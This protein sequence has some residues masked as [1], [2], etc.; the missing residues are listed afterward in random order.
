MRRYV[1]VLI[2]MSFFGSSFFLLEVGGFSLTLF[3]VALLLVALIDLCYKKINSKSVIF[4]SSTIIFILITTIIILLSLFINTP[5]LHWLSGLINL[6]LLLLFMNIIITNINEEDDLKNYIGAFLMG[7]FISMIVALFELN[8]GIKFTESYLNDYPVGSFEYTSLSKFPVAFLY[9]PNNLA[10]VLL[11]S[12]PVW[13]F[14]YFRFF[15]SKFNYLLNF[16]YKFIVIYCI[17][18]TGS[19]SSLLLSLAYLMYEYIS[20]KKYRVFYLMIVLVLSLFIYEIFKLNLPDFINDFAVRFDFDFE[21][22]LLFFINSYD[23]ARIDLIEKAINLSSKNY[24]IGGGPFYAESITGFPTHAFLIDIIADFGILGFGVFS[25]LILK[26]IRVI[27][28]TPS[29]Y[30]TNKYILSII[31]LFFIGSFVPPTIYTLFVYFIPLSFAYG[32]STIYS[33]KGRDNSEKNQFTIL[34]K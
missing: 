29:L 6:L 25:Y 19:R 24:F 5:S 3:R 7:C 11:L 1:S 33:M 16:I 31:F 27:K 32:V 23:K 13:N 14:Y 10:V 18:L 17:Y 2:L 12:L 8:L 4:R 15:K 26:L 30:R 28:S 21:K 22:G 20:T 34:N 9:N